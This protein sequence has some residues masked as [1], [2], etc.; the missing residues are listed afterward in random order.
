MINKSSLGDLNLIYLNTK[1]IFIRFIEIPVFY[2]KKKYLRFLIIILS[3]S[4]ALTYF[5]Q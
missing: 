2:D 4:Q 1:K 3:T 5:H